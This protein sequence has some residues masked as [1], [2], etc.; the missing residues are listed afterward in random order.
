MGESLLSGAAGSSKDPP[1]AR[2]DSNGS[3]GSSVDTVD[4][5]PITENAIPVVLLGCLDPTGISQEKLLVTGHF[6]E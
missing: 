2:L 3:A 6:S 1:V 5:V 4:M